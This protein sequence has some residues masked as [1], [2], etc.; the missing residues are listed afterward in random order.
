MI[1]ALNLSPN[2]PRA[3]IE[4]NT[5]LSVRVAGGGFQCG[6]VYGATDAIGL[7]AVENPVHL[8]DLYATIVNY[9]GLNQ[10]ALSYLHLGRKERLTEVRGTVIKDIVS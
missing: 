6:R 4:D 2:G 1:F 5:G 8:R 7:K 3:D 10:D 9:P